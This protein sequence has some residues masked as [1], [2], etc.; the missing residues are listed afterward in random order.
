MKLDRRIALVATLMI[1]A[2]LTN[3]KGSPTA[4]FNNRTYSVV[5]TIAVPATPTAPVTIATS[6]PNSHVQVTLPVAAVQAI[7]QAAGGG[8]SVKMNDMAPT[9]YGTLP[10][11]EHALIGPQPIATLVFDITKSSAAAGL[12]SASA[13]F[14]GISAA[15]VPSVVPVFLTLTNFSG[16]RCA[17]GPV[18]TFEIS[19]TTKLSLTGLSADNSTPNQIISGTVNLDFSFLHFV[20]DIECPL[21]TGGV[22]A[23]N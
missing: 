10:A 14:G 22:G 21:V 17:A 9:D 5:T 15:A 11:S 1:A 7:V 6:D 2:S 19:G 4:P 13:G 8:A 23:A 20:I 3:C 16:T 18:L 12:A